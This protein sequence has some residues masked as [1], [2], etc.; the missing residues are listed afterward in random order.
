MDDIEFDLFGQN[1]LSEPLRPD[2]AE[3][4]KSK[5]ELEQFNEA[6]REIYR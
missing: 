2:S 4:V 1:S 5:K 3:T 6:A